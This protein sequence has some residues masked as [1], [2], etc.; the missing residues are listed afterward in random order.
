MNA[1]HTQTEP[2]RLC[3]LLKEYAAKLRSNVEQLLLIHKSYDGVIDSSK[4]AFREQEARRQLAGLQPR[5]IYC[6]ETSRLAWLIDS[7]SLIMKPLETIMSR[8]SGLLEHAKL[9]SFL[10]DEL[11]L[12]LTEIKLERHHAL[13]AV[14][15]ITKVLGPEIKPRVT[16][17]SYMGGLDMSPIRKMM[18]A[19]AKVEN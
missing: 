2:E 18:S 14:I 3:D 1:I 8:A 10:V 4:L 19:S 9:D 7:V 6:D 12:R 13:S 11:T 5:T 16:N 17:A 15:E